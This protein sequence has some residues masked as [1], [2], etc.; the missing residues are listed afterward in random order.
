MCGILAAINHKRDRVDLI[1]ARKLMSFR[2]PDHQKD[3]FIDDMTYLGHNRL[4]IID[5]NERS[6]QPFRSKDYY[7]IFNGEIYNYR[8]LIVKHRLKIRTESDTEVLLEMY[9][10]YGHKCLD[11]FNGMF[12][13]LIYNTLSKDFFVA[14]DRLGI[15]PLFFYHMGNEWIFSSEIKPLQ[16]LVNSDIDDFG[17]RQFR[18]L[19]MTIKGYT[20]YKNIKTFPP[21][22]F[23]TN[24]KIQ[25]YWNLDI[26]S[27]PP[28]SDEEL[29][30]LLIDSVNLRK[31]SD[32]EVGSYLSGGL[33]STILTYLLKPNHT[34]TVGFAQN[35]EFNWSDLASKTLKSIHYKIKVDKK[36]FLKN[37]NFMI[38]ERGEPLSVPN[39]VIIFL[40]TKKVKSKNKVVLSG[41]GADELFFGYDRVFKWAHKS[42]TLD[43]KIFDKLYTYGSNID[44]EVVD[45]ALENLP[46]NKV[47]DKISYFFQIYHLHGLLRRLDFA[48]MLCSVEARVPFVDHRLVELTAGTPF[49]WKM[50]YSFK[51]PL[52]RIFSDILP[53]EIINREKV[54]FPVPLDYI[55]NGNKNKSEPM[56][57][58]LLHNIYEFKKTLNR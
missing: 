57:N 42:K 5:L 40:M 7:I 52:K 36:T 16:S 32:V 21:G 1:S 29:K 15:K 20:V 48:T 49:E 14:R 6:N 13:F 45:F 30:N 2:G 22:H 3:L 54:G 26:S 34:W 56:D 58:W 25:R 10:K 38:N 33:D 35:N 17:I 18:K 4:S 27:K 41:E 11:F 53:I 50:G 37:L 31:R 23:L 47:I 24:G 43:L 9:K 46:G 44:F 51:E 39:E 12:S 8:E 28:P 19:R 55:F